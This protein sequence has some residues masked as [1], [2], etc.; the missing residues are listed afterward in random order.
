M[1]T[2]LGSEVWA[3]IVDDDEST[4]DRATNL[5][6]KIAG[7]LDFVGN[8]IVWQA[9]L[10]DFL[11]RQSTNHFILLID[12]DVSVSQTSEEGRTADRGR[13][14]TNQSNLHDRPSH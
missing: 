2:R 11:G 1:K 12:G 4:I 10:W 5:D 7:E 9:I 13:A 8:D 3:E 6:A 14:A